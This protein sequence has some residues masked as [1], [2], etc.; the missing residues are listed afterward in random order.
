MKKSC[1]AFQG[2]PTCRGET[3]RLPELSRPLRRVRDPDANGWLILQRNK[4]KLT[5]AR[6]TWGRVDSVV[7]GARDHI[8]GA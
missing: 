4:L 7:S 5:L 3:T 2:Y 6:V 8:N 1:P